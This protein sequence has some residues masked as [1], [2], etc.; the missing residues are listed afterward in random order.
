MGVGEQTGAFTPYVNP[1]ET[2]TGHILLSPF[3]LRGSACQAMQAYHAEICC[4]FNEF[5]QPVYY[6]SST[7][8]FPI[9]SQHISGPAFTGLGLCVSWELI[10]LIHAEVGFAFIRPSVFRLQGTQRSRFSRVTPN[11]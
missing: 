6:G 7:G 1:S 10:P 3:A 11:P 9:L 5:L 8:Q 2:H 4:R